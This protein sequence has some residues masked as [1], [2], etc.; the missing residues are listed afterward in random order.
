[1]HHSGREVHRWIRSRFFA[2]LPGD[3][4]L[5]RQAVAVPARNVGRAI[6]TEGFIPDSDILEGLVQRGADVHITVGEGRSIM[7]DEG[8]SAAARLA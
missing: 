7:E 6:A 3:F 1:M 2:K 5:D 4:L 8:F